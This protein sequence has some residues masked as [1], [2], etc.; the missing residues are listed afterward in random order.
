MYG[1]TVSRRAQRHAVDPELHADDA[2][3]VRRARLHGIVPTTVPAAGLVKLTAGGC[4]S[5]D[6]TSVRNVMG[7]AVC[8]LLAPSRAFT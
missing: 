4:V 5:A 1:A 7:D 6:A 3:V 2:D 8:W